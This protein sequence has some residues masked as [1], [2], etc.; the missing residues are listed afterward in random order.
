[1]QQ[2]WEGRGGKDR[3]GGRGGGRGAEGATKAMPK[4]SRKRGGAVGEGGQSR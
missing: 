1:M 2:K 3:A 4:N